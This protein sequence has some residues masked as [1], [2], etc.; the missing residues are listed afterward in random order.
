MGCGPQAKDGRGGGDSGPALARAGALEDEAAVGV[1]VDGLA[2]EHGLASRSTEPRLDLDAPEEAAPRRHARAG[3][4]AG[5]ARRA[6]LVET[7]LR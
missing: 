1:A 4:A 6:V 7:A 5:E 2:V 3:A